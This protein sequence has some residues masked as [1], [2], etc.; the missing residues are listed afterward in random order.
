MSFP[1]L[2]VF[3]IIMYVVI[4]PIYA[5]YL[6]THPPRL[7]VSFRTPADLGASYE[8]VTLNSQDGVRLSGWY[9]P[10]RNG[11]A[12]IL[13]H[14]HGGN[15]LGVM[16]HAEVLIK[17]GYGVL[18]F[19]LRAHGSSG[20][21]LFTRGKEM[22][23]D[24]LAAVAYLS[25]QPDVT[26]D[27]IGIFGVSVGGL[28][29]IQA[30]ARTVAIR[31]VAAD[32]ASPATLRD[33]PPPRAWFDRLVNRPLNHY[34]MRAVYF[35]SRTATLPPLMETLPR[36]ALR[37]LFL[38]ATGRTAEQQLTRQFYEAAGQ[39][40]ML[41]EIPEAAHAAGWRARPEIYAEKLTAFFDA[42]LLRQNAGPLT[43]H[44]V[45]QPAPDA[46]EQ[47]ISADAVAY[48]ATI[49]MLAANGIALIMLPVAFIL[50][51]LPYWLIWGNRLSGT[52][53]TL[54]L[55]SLVTM[56]L[57]LAVAIVVHELL[58]AAGCVLLGK[59]SLSAVSFGFNWKALAPFAHC[60]APLT[61]R[62]YRVTVALPGLLL[63]LLPGMAGV[64]SGSLLLLVGGILMLVAAG[65]DAAVL[66]A[67]RRVPGDAT[68]LDH[69]SR[70][71]CRVLNARDA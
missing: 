27:G 57:G 32:G 31:A 9:V 34:Y 41:W 46:A 35:F 47:G 36:L 21:R 13:L 2:V 29:A 51:A 26:A 3:I 43:G 6:F 45:D 61:A 38:I 70:A 65:G 66:W 28:V 59:A 1:E 62:A 69:P 50:L 25:K 14:G 67:M 11:A 44:F 63:G 5:A 18:M 15:R 64:L 48:D 60:R 4:R 17:A 68:V 71:G 49:S 53:I 23:D 12:V 40:K 24:V 19:D 39:P 16:F 7:R 55:P 52:S 20:G 42:A 37:P 54:T 8:D 33:L 10:S 22:V 56:L 30:A 58:H